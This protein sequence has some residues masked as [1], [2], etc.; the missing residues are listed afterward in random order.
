MRLSVTTDAAPIRVTGDGV[1]MVGDTRVPLATLVHEFRAGATPEQIVDDFDT[2]D[3]ADVY[4]AIAY[5]LR[6]QAEVDA[7]LREQD[8]L[9]AEVRARHLRRFPQTGLRERLTQRLVGRSDR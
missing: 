4:A 5:Y 7:Y 3:L 2:L 8:E 9:A 1:A 6:H